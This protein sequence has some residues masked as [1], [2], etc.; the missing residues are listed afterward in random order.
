MS[1]ECQTIMKTAHQSHGY[2]SKCKYIVL[3]IVLNKKSSSKHYKINKL[4][5]KRLRERILLL[6]R[7]FRH[8]ILT[9]E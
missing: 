6:D 5:S 9:V 3:A 8:T 2:L 4:P 7:L 1:I